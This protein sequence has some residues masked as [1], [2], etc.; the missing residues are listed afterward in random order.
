MMAAI[1]EARDL[2]KR[3]DSFTAVDHI[4]FAV[5]EGVIFGFLGRKNRVGQSTRRFDAIPA[6]VAQKDTKF[7]DHPVD[8]TFII[9]VGALE[10]F[11]GMGIEK[12][13]SA[14]AGAQPRPPFAATL[15]I[16]RPMTETGVD[17]L[18]SPLTPGRD[19]S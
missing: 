3:F 6:M 5:P 11:A 14:Q 7:V 12:A 13:Q 16:L 10:I 9:A 17:P 15:S 19:S 8:R 2:V 18:A 4:S 1:I